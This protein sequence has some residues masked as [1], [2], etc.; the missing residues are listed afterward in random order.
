MRLFFVWFYLQF[1]SFMG[2]YVL[3]KTPCFA[4]TFAIY[5]NVPGFSYRYTILRYRAS[6]LR[7]DHCWDNSSNRV[8]LVLYCVLSTWGC[9]WDQVFGAN[10]NF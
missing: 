8:T 6:K 2:V 10:D 9:E 4:G 5:R 1:I 7:A 3:Y